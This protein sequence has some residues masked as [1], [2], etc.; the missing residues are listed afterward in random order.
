MAGMPTRQRSLPDS[1]RRPFYHEPER[2]VSHPDVDAV[3]IGLSNDMHLEA[4]L[5]SRSGKNMSLHQTLAAMFEALQMLQ[6]VDKAGITGGYLEDL[7]YTPKVSEITGQHPERSDWRS[8]L[9]QSR[10]THPARTANG[11]GIRK[12]REVAPLLISVAIVW[13]SAAILSAKISGR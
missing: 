12:K 11:S 13:R 3:I 4:V 10:E 1:T 2:I 8:N 6:A 9:G 5:A 7:C